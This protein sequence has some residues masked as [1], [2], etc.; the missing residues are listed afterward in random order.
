M[1]ITVTTEREEGEEEEEKKKTWLKSDLSLS[2]SVITCAKVT[3][4]VD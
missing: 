2:A 3:I 1:I 4:K